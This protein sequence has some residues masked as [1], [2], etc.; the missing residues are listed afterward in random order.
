M[1]KSLFVKPVSLTTITSVLFGLWYILIFYYTS[2][3][4]FTYKFELEWMEGSMLEHARVILNGGNIFGAPS[5][6]FTPFIY[7]PLYYAICAPL[8]SFFTNGLTA[9]RLVSIISFSLTIVLMYK[10]VLK[11]RNCRYCAFFSAAFFS[12][13]FEVC[14]AWFD[15]ARVDSTALF[16]I[17][18]FFYIVRFAGFKHY[19]AAAGLVFTLA[20][21]CKQSN[22]IAA[23]PF[24]IYAAFT[25]FKKYIPLITVSSLSSAAAFLA[26]NARSDNF[27]GYYAYY[28]PAAHAIDKSLI[29]GFWTGDLLPKIPAAT[30]LSFFYLAYIYFDKTENGRPGFYF[31]LS[32]G[33]IS[34]AWLARIHEGG[35][36]NVIMPACAAFAL[37]SALALKPAGERLVYYFKSGPQS[38]APHRVIQTLLTA[39]FLLLIYNPFIY[40]PA[41]ADLAAGCA[42][43][44]K[45]TDYKGE[46]YIPYHPYLALMAGKKG[47]RA[48]HMA[49]FDVLRGDKGGKNFITINEA[50]TGYISNKKAEVII[51]DNLNFSHIGL[52]RKNY[53]YKEPVFDHG[54]FYPVS[55]MKTRPEHIF[56]KKK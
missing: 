50:L 18:L 9:M 16:L 46:V 35:C 54:Y 40:I 52:I 28:L 51:V 41:E 19:Q 56:V 14:G 39:Q 22:M 47:P 26:L 53:D 17:V 5:V 29:Y 13:C 45:I 37:L 33:L 21:L 25:D 27:F 1:K 44:E 48:H 34:A 49:V 36:L 8:L 55:G 7:S 38:P 10:W 31:S 2:A 43:I 3:A 30:A 4:R 11:E 24:F 42:L 20:W 23:A 6:E 15:I 12:A 32:L